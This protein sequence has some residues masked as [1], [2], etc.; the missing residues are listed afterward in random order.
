MTQ[1][2]SFDRLLVRL[3]LLALL[4]AAINAWSVRH[5]G[6]DFT[7][8]SLLNAAAAVFGVLLTLLRDREQKLVEG[9]KKEVRRPRYHLQAFSWSLEDRSRTSAWTCRPGLI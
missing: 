2:T 4:L 7:K 3:V 9:D 1:P 6:I 5:L 8:L